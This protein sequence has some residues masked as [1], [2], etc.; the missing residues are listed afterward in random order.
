MWIIL[1]FI[2]IFIYIQINNG[3]THLKQWQKYHLIIHPRHPGM[4]IAIDSWFLLLSIEF[5]FFMC[6][7]VS[8]WG[9][10]NRVC[11]SVRLSVP[12]EKKS[13]C[14]CQYQSYISNWYINGKFNTAWNPNNTIF[15]KQVKIEFWLVFWFVLKC[16]N[17][18]SF[19]NISPT[20]VLIHQWKG[21]H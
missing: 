18:S 3:I 1:Y 7:H 12:R 6:G 2:I 14:F 10:R 16:W 8:I 11:L 9:Y 5:K 15:S 13:P 20:V 17:H 19:F 4:H 21:L